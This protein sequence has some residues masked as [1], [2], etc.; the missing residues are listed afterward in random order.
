MRLLSR[1][2][3]EYFLLF[4]VFVCYLAVLMTSNLSCR[5]APSGLCA[6]IKLSLARTT[7]HSFI[8][9]VLLFPSETT[10]HLP[11][12]FPSFFELVV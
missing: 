2:S 4:T 7:A 3:T 9:L 12:W 11:L 1:L 10:E 8:F 6:F 5:P